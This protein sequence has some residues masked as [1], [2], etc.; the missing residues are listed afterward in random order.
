LDQSEIYLSY[1]D[2]DVIVGVFVQGEESEQTM[3]FLVDTTSWTILANP[4]YI[5]S[6]VYTE[7]YAGVGF[8][9]S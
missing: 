2:S 5:W 8:I 1:E 4:E 3:L 9:R 7:T 6:H